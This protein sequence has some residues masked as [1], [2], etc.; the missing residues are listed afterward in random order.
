VF[1][2]T[3]SSSAS[4]SELLINNLK[5]YM[6][7][8]I[9]GKPTHGKPVG[10]YGFNVMDYVL[11]PIAF[12]TVNAQNIGDYYNGL[13][14]DANINDGLDRNWGD[15]QELCLASAFKYIQQGV[16]ARIAT[17][18]ASA[19]LSTQQVQ[20]NDFDQKIVKELII[21]APKFK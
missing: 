17:P 21:K 7:V 11:A 14:V 10:M 19:R 5:P 16:F 9:I 8:K 18:N 15:P 6:D 1:F 20:N 12:K 3:T 4:A 2:I 13:A